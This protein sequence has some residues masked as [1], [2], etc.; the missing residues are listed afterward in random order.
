MAKWYG[1]IGYAETVESPVG[2]GIYVES[3]TKKDYYGDVLRSK[4]FIQNSNEINDNINI[5]NQISIVADP[6]AYKN[7]HLMRYVEFMGTK[8]K[9]SDVEVQYPRLVL[10]LGGVYNEE[11]SDPASGI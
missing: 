11:S 10:S 9:V 2:S 7:F 5:S 8:W 3:I 4:K 6:F 1:E